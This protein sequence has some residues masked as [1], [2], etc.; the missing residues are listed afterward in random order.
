MLCIRTKLQSNVFVH[1]YGVST[2]TPAFGNFQH[3]RLSSTCILWVY[4]PLCIQPCIWQKL[5]HA[6]WPGRKELEEASAPGLGQKQNF[7]LH[8]NVNEPNPLTPSIVQ[9]AKHPSPPN[10]HHHPPSLPPTLNPSALSWMAPT[11]CGAERKF[12]LR[13]VVS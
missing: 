7:D 1:N 12:Y 5:W 13:F 3:Q 2:E 8:S 10:H 11:V 6:A 4:Y 9:K